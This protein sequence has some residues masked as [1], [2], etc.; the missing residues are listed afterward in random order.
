MKQIVRKRDKFLFAFA[1]LGIASPAA[2]DDANYV[3]RI[4]NDTPG[5]VTVSINKGAGGCVA[6]NDGKTPEKTF[7]IPPA[8]AIAIGFWR[9]SSCH[10]K[11]GDLAIN[12]WGDYLPSHTEAGNDYQH[13]TFDAAGTIFRYPP[14]ANYPNWMEPSVNVMGPTV[15]FEFHVQ[16]VGR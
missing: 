10:G 11:Q 15:A 5:A 2:A 3:V 16:P 7:A 13:F 12:A 1:L 9:S 6:F 4:L 14:F 8:A